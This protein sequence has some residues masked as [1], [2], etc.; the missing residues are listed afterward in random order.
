[1]GNLTLPWWG[2]EFEPKLSRAEYLFRP[3]P[4]KHM[5]LSQNMGQFKEKNITFV[6]KWLIEKGLTKLVCSVFEGV[7]E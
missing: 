2:G 1:M 3:V 4:I 5:W 7:Y 6:S